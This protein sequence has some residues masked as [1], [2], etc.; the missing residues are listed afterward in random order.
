M[1]LG[2][3]KEETEV[4]WPKISGSIPMGHSLVLLNPIVWW[5]T[6]W[7]LVMVEG[8]MTPGQCRWDYT[9]LTKCA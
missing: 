4:G 5:P 1:V 3:A 7:T 2:F 6:A 8:V 9:L